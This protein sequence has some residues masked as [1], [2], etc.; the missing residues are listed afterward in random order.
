MKFRAIATISLSLLCGLGIGIGLQRYLTTSEQGNALLRRVGLS[1]YFQSPEAAIP[2]LDPINPTVPLRIQGRLKLYVLMGQSNMVGK[3]RIPENLSPSAN[4]Y[5]F[6]NNYRWT[7]ATAPIDDAT[8]QVDVVS[9]D[10]FTGFGPAFI[11]AKTLVSQNSNQFIGLIPCARSGSSITE[12]QRNL[13]DE[14][15]YGSCLKRVRAASPMGTVAG[16]LFF[17]GEAD[18]I[19]PQQ[20]PNLQPD[21]DAWAEKF[22]LFAYNFRQDIGSPN[23]PFIYAQLGQP[24]DLEGL[25][26]WA[27]VQQQQ[28]SIQIPNGVMIETRDLPMDGIHFTPDSYQIIGQRFAEAINQLS[29]DTAPIADSNNPTGESPAP[30]SAQ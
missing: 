13:S 29:P 27:Q 17:Q 18:T 19:N 25:P 15:L 24:E 16:I 20:F 28:A 8:D 23:T 30:E 2:T 14:T 26:N 7:I 12:W 3:A 21:A 11:F 1:E 5:S 6:G 10:K 4:I 22:A 9:H